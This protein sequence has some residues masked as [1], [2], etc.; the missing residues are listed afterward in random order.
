MTYIHRLPTGELSVRINP[1]S[2]ATVN[3]SLSDVE[4]VAN[5][6]KAWDVEAETRR[7]EA[8]AAKEQANGAPDVSQVDI[9]VGEQA[10]AILERLRDLLGV[11]SLGAVEA[12]VE[13]MAMV[14]EV[15]TE[16]PPEALPGVWKH[17]RVGTLDRR[18]PPLAG[19]WV[20]NRPVFEDAKGNQ[21]ECITFCFGERF[22]RVKEGP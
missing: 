7:N 6:I 12:E 14:P 3:A 17:H 19:R 11:P 10:V 21:H 22:E 4:R 18:L 8:Q 20:A 13:R 2:D 1:A 15:V 9:V 16:W 5:L